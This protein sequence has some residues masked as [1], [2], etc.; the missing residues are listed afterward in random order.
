MNTPK[1]TITDIGFDP[2]NPNNVKLRYNGLTDVVDIGLLPEHVTKIKE[3]Y[4][5]YPS[6]VRPETEPDGLTDVPHPDVMD[7]A[8][9][10]Y[11][12][13][14][15]VDRFLEEVNELCKALLK[16]RRTDLPEERFNPD[17]IDKNIQ[18]EIGDVLITLSQVIKI[19]GNKTDEIK[20]SMERK[21]TR[22]QGQLRKDGHL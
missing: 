8:I 2:V 9:E 11:G 19:Y 20:A 4:E 12:K 17:A 1:I 5:S 22:L 18:E 16:R 21:V 3:W 15:Q 13:E 6:L 14:Y 7:K 10:V